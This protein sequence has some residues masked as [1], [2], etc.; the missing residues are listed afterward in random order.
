MSNS[1]FLLSDISTIKGVG[2]KTRKYLQKKK[3]EKVKDLLWDL[4]YSFIDRSKI[5]SLDKLEIGKILTVRV[6][7]L[8]YNFPRMRNLPNTVI[9]G[10]DNKKIKIVFFNSYEGYIRKILPLNKSVIISGK[11]NYYKSNYQITNPTYVK[12]VEHVDEIAKIFPKYSL[13]DGLLEKNYRKLIENVIKKIDDSFEWHDNSFLQNNNFKS[14]KT[15]LNNL[16]NPEN[17]LD[18]FS[19]DFRRLAYDEILSN[20]LTLYSARKVIKIKKKRKKIFKNKLSDI[21]RKN[22][23]FNLTKGQ[24]KILAEIDKDLKSDSRMFRLLQG[25]VG[26]G[27][28][29]LALIAA[30][31]V[32][33]DGFQ[34]AFMAPTEILA[35]QHYELALN[36]FNKTRINIG[37]LTSKIV[38]SDKNKIINNLSNGNINFLFGTHSLFQKKIKFLNLGF[39]IIDEQHKFGVKQRIKLAKKGGD[40]CDVLSMSATPIPRTMMLSFFGDMDISILNE[41]PKHR[42]E[43]VTLIKPENKL[44][45]IIPLIEKQIKLNYQ[46]FWVCPLIEESKKLNFSS[47]KKKFNDICK[48][49]PNNVGLIHG[50][51]SIEDRNKVL[52]L[53]INKKIKILVSTTIIEVGINFPDANIIIIEDANKFGL[54]QLHQLR[55]RVGRGRSIS[56]C[57]LIYKKN[58]SQN[59]KKRLKILRETNSGFIIAEEDL[60]IRGH[61]DLLGFQQSG[62][63]NFKFADPVHHKDL[64][65][66]AENKL[67]TFNSSSLKKYEKL[68]KLYDRADIINQIK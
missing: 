35:K 19:N 22:F 28:T 58:L 59:A 17:N 50:N 8:K 34:V 62:I 25:D 13:T 5:T 9:C 65:L 14:L 27:K 43:I 51:M 30:A 18:I 40:N 11:I 15:T 36:L 67:N 38:S 6:D 42:K 33:E 57:I 64:F 41:K 47:A 1:N 60:K 55:G 56:Y 39:I 32:L 26:S 20:L 31:N 45:E 4:P 48:L 29:I 44:N 63:K 7:V 61:G 52:N 21:V 23:G 53:F 68:I 54:S 46:V 10:D 66:S 37:L 24:N 3:I 49:F 12:P 16:H 2:T